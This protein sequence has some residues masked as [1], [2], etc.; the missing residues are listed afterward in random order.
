MIERKDGSVEGIYVD[1]LREAFGR[2]GYEVRFSHLPFKRA[3][4]MLKGKRIDAVASFF[5]AKKRESFAVYPRIP[6][7]NYKMVFMARK[8]VLISFSGDYADLAPYSIVVLR[9]SSYVPEFIGAIRRHNLNIFSV[10]DFD[11]SAAMILNRRV[12]LAAVELYSALESL[13]KINGLDKVRFL[14]PPIGIVP[15][16]IAF[17]KD[18]V[19][20]EVVK[21][22]EKALESMQSENYLELIL[23]KYFPSRILNPR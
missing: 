19:P 1:L 14:E 5:Y 21:A 11:Q 23:R 18:R 7:M 13:R 8:D 4:M 12:D 3:L 16:Y 6:V 17:A 9:G 22:V 15:T 20:R 10:N 2:A